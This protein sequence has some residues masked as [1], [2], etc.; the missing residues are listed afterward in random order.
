MVLQEVRGTDRCLDIE[1][2]LIETLDQRKCFFLILICQSNDNRTIILHLDS[3]SLKGFKECAVQAL[4]IADRLTCGLHLRREIS[5]HTVEFLETKG[6]CFDIPAVGRLRR[7]ELR[8]A[9]ICQRFAEHDTGRDRYEILVCGLRKER[10]RTGST[11]VDLD[12]I[13]AVVLVDDELN[14][15]KTHDT[16]AEAQARGVI[17]DG[18]LDLIG[19]GER[20]INAGTVTTMD[21]GT[22]YEF[23]DTRD[24]YLLAVADRVD[25]DFFTDEVFIDEDRF[26]FVYFNGVL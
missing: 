26:I 15:E 3:G 7:G 2:E 19:D 8:D 23:H 24:E 14:I 12:D 13:D 18:L 1:A 25:L 20:R 22:L 11:R 16:D 21:T 17:A 9:L 10:Y 5:I 4:V 6:R